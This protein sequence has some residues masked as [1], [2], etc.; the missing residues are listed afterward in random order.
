MKSKVLFFSALVATL[1]VTAVIAFTVRA[2]EVAE[3]SAATD[4]KLVITPAEAAVV[5]AHKIVEPKGA[6][7]EANYIIQLQDPPL[8][9]YTGSKTGLAA[10]NPAVN[11]ET[12][13]KS[14]AATDAY[15][16][17]LS[18]TQA[19]AIAEAEQA[20]GRP[21]AVSRAFQ[22][23]FNGFVAPITPEEAQAI[24]AL[25]SVKM[26]FRETFE[27]LLTDAGPAWIG[28]PAIWNG[29]ATGGLPGTQGE[30]I[31]VAILDTGINST[32]P[33]FADVGDD[34]YDHTNPLGS[35]NYIPGS[36]CA[37]VPSFCNDK[38]IGAWDMV[39]DPTDPNA[40]EDSDGH[41]S[42]TAST[43]AGNVLTATFHAPTT[44]ITDTISGVAPHANIIAYD[45]CITNCPG[46][47]LLAAVNQVV[48]DAMALPNGIAALNYSISGGALPYS[49]PVELAFLAAADAGV[50]VSASAGNSGPVAASV[51]HR[52]P[53]VATVGASTHNR[54]LSNDVVG[55]TG[56]DTTPPADIVGAG[57][58]TSYGPA[59]IVYAGDFGD[60]LCLN[61]FPAGT[62]TNGEI[63]VCDR[64]TIARVAKGQNVLAGGAGGMVLADDGNGI[65]ADAHFL[66]ASHINQADG[67]ALKTW[68]ASGSG[69]M[70]SISGT[71][72][73]LSPTNGDIMAGFS[74][75]GPNTTLDVLKPDVTAPGVSIWAAVENDGSGPPDYG[76]L[77]GTSMSSPHNA[78][79]GA[80]MAA[81]HPD[82]SPHQIKSALMTTSWTANV[83]KEDGATP[84]D[85]FD[86]GAGRIDLN[87]A[88]NAGLLLDETTANF[89]AAEFGDPK[90]LNIASFADDQCFG[91]C[92]WTRV[93]E[94]SASVTV[95]WNAEVTPPPDVILSVSP[96]SF[97]LAPG[98]TQTIT[99]TADVSAAAPDT[100]WVF[101]EVRLVPFTGYDI[102]LPIIFRSG[103]S[104]QGNGLTQANA[105]TTPT[106]HEEYPA[107]HFPLAVY[108]A[109]P[110]CQLGKSN[111]ITTED[112]GSWDVTTSC[113]LDITDFTT[114][115][116]GLVAGTLDTR[117]LSEDP[118][119]DDPYDNLNDGTTFF[120]TTTVAA[121]DLLLVAE[122]FD[123]EA[124]DMDLFVGTG[125]T[126][127][128]A[129][130][131][132]SST[133]GT[134]DEV[135]K[136]ENP[137]D[138]A[139]GT[140]WILVQ[141]WNESGSPPDNV[142]LSY[143]VLDAVDAGNMTVT[144]PTMVNAG[145]VFTAT[146]SWNQ[147]M[148]EGDRW[149][150]A[151]TLGTDAGNAGNLGTYLV[152]LIRVGL[153]PVIM[154]APAVL[155]TT[156]PTDTQIIHTLTIS[157]VGG[158][159]LNWSID[160]ASG[161]LSSHTPMATGDAA[162]LSE[163]V[164]TAVSS[165]AS[166][167]SVNAPVFDW[168]EVVL[169]DNG[170]LVNCAGCGAGGADES[171]VQNVT[172]GMTTL[173]LGHQVS[174]GNRIA[175]DFTVSD[176]SGWTID[177]ITFFA[178]QTNSPITSTMTAVNLR[179]WNGSPDD[180]GSSVVFG[181]TSTNILTATTWS[182]I[183]RVSETSSGGTTRPI[184]AN[185]ADLGGFYLPAGTYWLDWQTDGSLASGPWAPPITVNGVLTTGNG[186]QFTGAW[187]PADDG[188]SFTQQGFPF[189]IE[190]DVGGTGGGGCTF[191]SDL[192]WLSV[193][194]TSGT[195][196]AGT[197]SAV[198]VT[199][200]STGLAT[201]VYTGTLCI[202]SNDPVTPLVEV[203]VSMTVAPATWSDSFDFYA[204][205]SQMHG[206]GG[207]KGWDNAPSA[208][209]LTSSAQARS[210]PNSVDIMLDADLVH[211]YSGATSG[212]WVYTAWQYIPSGFTGTTF[213]ILLNTYSDGGTKN[214]STQVNFNSGTGL[215][216]NDGASGGTL[217]LV[218]GQWVPIRVEIDLD[219]DTQDFYYNHQLL[220]SGTWT[221][222]V[223]GG[224]A[225]NIGAVD[226]FANGATSAFYDDISLIAVP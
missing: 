113:D 95:T 87:M 97:E 131:V 219:Q 11:G 221:D 194:P 135:C 45:V 130:E 108:P 127:S 195:T 92:S 23:A 19:A 199:F 175:D 5:T 213:F 183:Y 116:F 101:G 215:V 80:L 128:A 112:T 160:E 121:G 202:D 107:A 111:I 81:L 129:T 24:A 210:A 40:P 31:V 86:M 167:P 154:V 120:V 38:L 43:V 27:E 159:D 198:D 207:W 58:T 13:L 2:Q 25:A 117:Q 109:S 150:G 189:I 184:M 126:P 32:H 29:T 158:G 193:S 217:P 209:A 59:P 203:P 12:K 145:D 110:A 163:E 18:D 114:E 33:S 98:E 211:E 208:G 103:S 10:T 197:S 89:Q 53:W 174:A 65:V 142:T 88:G 161:L 188:G 168:P 17:Y 75:R 34:G 82:W 169:Y 214:W 66:P 223:S 72:V 30:G 185:T 28:A 133:S 74:S 153:D 139:T 49:D 186:L 42:H 63:V 132:C 170:P 9:S 138:I 104:T 204:T 172:L 64:G 8:A 212:Q 140:W 156:V 119:N 115:P 105:P 177:T 176:P 83:L 1:V 190:G 22:H 57:F 90:D 55:L 196:A 61:P 134:A 56:G 181:D 51:A 162:S 166:M 6:T 147:V 7:G 137:G 123:S 67:T 50:F 225:A 84:A 15:L 100:A 143:A 37:T 35:G 155:D 201:G 14:S 125:D 3:F 69:H 68:L 200:D 99:V 141:N 192:P 226:L 78:G 152:N 70:G 222:E 4:S 62:W 36:H 73:D 39:N 52:S 165:A 26:V 21:L 47:A 20:I 85:P 76:F 164:G 149:Y 151:F 220:Y 106:T 136:I 118:T 91:T 157:N 94:S 93:V 41:G 148:T 71:M 224:G 205:G 122:T 124:P 79:A 191:P 144:G 182:N 46:T 180:P 77:S 216:S 96:A 16:A 173:G 48:I 54:L 218:T 60:G 178:Y 171:Q 146:I 187:A 206:Q 179:I 102:Y 44:A